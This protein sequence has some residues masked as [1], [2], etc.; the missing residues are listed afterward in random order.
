MLS[1]S[2]TCLLPRPLLAADWTAPSKA[3]SQ[4]LTQQPVSQSHIQQPVTHSA[5][6]QPVTH[7][8]ASHSLSNQSASHTFSSQPATA[9]KHRCKLHTATHPA[10]GHHPPSHQQGTQQGTQPVC[11]KSAQPLHPLKTALH[12]LLAALRQTALHP[13]TA[14]CTHSI[15]HTAAPTPCSTGAPAIPRFLPD[16]FLPSDLSLARQP[17]PTPPAGGGWVR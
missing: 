8:A 13:S 4:S 3:T 11:L 10:V 17:S 6:S 12:P 1:L 5:T 15:L 9:P 7:S 14:H 2:S 16:I